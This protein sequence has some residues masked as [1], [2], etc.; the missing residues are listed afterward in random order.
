MPVDHVRDSAVSALVRVLDGQA[1]V[2]TTLDRAMRRRKFSPRGGRFLTHLVYGVTRH[3]LLCDYIL[4]QLCEQPLD[5]LP[6]PVLMVLRMGV[7]Q[8]LFCDNVTRPAMVHSAV[9]LAR[10]HGHPGLARLTNAVL[11]RVPERLEHVVLPDRTQDPANYLRLRYSMPRWIV[12]FWL[13]RYGE[14]G[15]ERMCACCNAPAPCSIRVNTL[16]TD[17]ATLSRRLTAAGFAVTGVHEALEGL[18]VSGDS[19]PVHTSLFREGCFMMQDPASML[20]ARLVAPEPGERIL[21]M[22]AA[23]GGKTTH[24]AALAENRASIIAME[25]YPGRIA[26]IR[27]NCERM[28]VAGVH[29]VCG[30]GLSPPSQDGAFDRVLLDAPCSGLGTLRRHPEIKWRTG[31]EVPPRLAETQRA[32]LRTAARLCK[33]GGLIVYS[34]CTFTPEETLDAVQELLSEGSCVPE[35]GLELFNTWKTAPGQYQTSPADA[36]WDGFFLMRFRKRS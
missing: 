11:R 17:T 27:D 34:V 9:E 10:K 4:Q 16:T 13:S 12:R 22:C 20:A 3:K 25:R 18:I 23:P 29:T 19:H 15:A 30:D 8:A 21:D 5:N 14:D 35:D 28:G 7:F 31:P 1:P 36:A 26:L 24:L 2:D 33:N 32:L 6:P